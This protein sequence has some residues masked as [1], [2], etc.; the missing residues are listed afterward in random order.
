MLLRLE[1]LRQVRPEAHKSGV[2][3]ECWP[4]FDQDDP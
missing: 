1:G 2:G 4:E 3:A